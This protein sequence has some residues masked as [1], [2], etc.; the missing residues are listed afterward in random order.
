[1]LNDSKLVWMIL[2]MAVGEESLIKGRI[3]LRID[4]KEYRVHP[5]HERAGG[6]NTWWVKKSHDEIFDV[7]NFRVEL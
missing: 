5:E 6:P 3:W 2:R 4:E 7:L 1:M